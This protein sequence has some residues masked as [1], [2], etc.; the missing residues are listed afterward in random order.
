MT[1]RTLNRRHAGRLAFTAALLAVVLA[2]GT[3]APVSAQVA[4]LHPDLMPP[5]DPCVSTVFLPPPILTYDLDPPSGTEDFS[6]GIRIHVE[7][8]WSR[9][10]RPVALI[11]NGNGFSMAHYTDFAEYLARQ[12][13]VAAVARR[14]SGVVYDVDTFVLDSLAAV[15]DHQGLPPTTPAALIGHSVGGRFVLDAAARI[16]RD[17]HS[18]T[19]S[20]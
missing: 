20:I 18:L 16:G 7:Q 9:Q 17:R 19:V 14:P 6:A 1:H 4:Q 5:P 15:L 8:T 3:A 10:Q 11:V 13:F 12:G 2:A